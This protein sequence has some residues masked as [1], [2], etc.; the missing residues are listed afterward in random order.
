RYAVLDRDDW[1]ITLEGGL[2]GSDHVKQIRRLAYEELLWLANDVSKRQQD[3][4]SGGNLSPQAAAR[5]ALS[6]LEKA[7]RAHRPT[8]AFYV[9]RAVLHKILGEEA[10]FE[11]DWQRAAKTPPTLALDHYL[12]GEAAF[13]A[14]QLQKAVADFQEALFLEPTHYWSLL[15]LATCWG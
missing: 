2:L 7:E 15:R 3:H 8:R 12:R 9:Q 5:R 1:P 6:Y 10:A 14:K 4:R 13:D 11:S